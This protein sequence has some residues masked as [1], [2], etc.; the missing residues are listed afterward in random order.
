MGRKRFTARVSREIAAK[1]RDLFDAWT[2]PKRPASPWSKR[3][4][5]RLVIMKPHVGELFHIN[6]GPPMP[7]PTHYGRFVRLDKPNLIE[8]TW[9]SEGTQG[10]E[11]RV[12]IS[13]KAKGTGTQFSLRHTGLPSAASA[14]GHEEGWGMIIG[15]LAAGVESPKR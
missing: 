8:H 7:L 15:W 9:A 12:R 2:D 14:R 1:P 11:T 5:I 6:M 4:G 3:N 13:L 10:I